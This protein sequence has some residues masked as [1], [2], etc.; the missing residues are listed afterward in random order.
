M[1]DQT[2][3]ISDVAL[4]DA[5]LTERRKFWGMWTRAVTGAAIVVTLLLIVLRLFVA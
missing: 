4:Q 2:T 1:A 3:T 5:L